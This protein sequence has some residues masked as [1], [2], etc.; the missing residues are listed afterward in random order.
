MGTYGFLRIVLPVTPDGFTRIAPAVAVLATVAILWGAY[1]CLGQTDMKRLIAFSSVAHMGFVMLALATLSGPGLQ[2]A[3]FGNVAHG[4]I[5]GLLF[6]VV[7]A[8]KHRY[9][10]SDLRVMPRG[11]YGRAPHLGGLL[12]FAGFASLGLPGLAGFWGEFLTLYGVYLPDPALSRVLY[13]VLLALACVGAVLA[14][15]YV[16]RLL[17]RVLQGPQDPVGATPVLALSHGPGAQGP[18]EPAALPDVTRG[19]WLAWSPLVVVILALGLWPQLLLGITAPATGTL[20]AALG[21]GS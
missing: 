5:T 11:L 7:G 3:Q 20:L 12:L 1:A 9:G 15:A 13:L 4:V 6:F 14:A 16:L 21:V 19:E 17:R 10:T 18:V 2:G 8:I